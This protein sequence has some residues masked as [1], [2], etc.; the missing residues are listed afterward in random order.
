MRTKGPP[1][2]GKSIEQQIL[3][4]IGSSVSDEKP[5]F[6]RVPPVKKPFQIPLIAKVGEK[7]VEDARAI[8][9][10]KRKDSP[11]STPVEEGYTMV[12]TNTKGGGGALLGGT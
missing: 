6:V 1:V 12:K 4:D 2:Y 9:D 3:K 5:V 10:K 8:L 7:T 11:A